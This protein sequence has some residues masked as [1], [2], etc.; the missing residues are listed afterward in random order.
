MSDTSASTS[1]L[2]SNSSF[3]Y[4]TSE[5]SINYGSVV[6]VYLEKY[7]EFP[8]IGK[9]ENSSEDT[10]TI[11][12]FD[13][14]FNDVWS[15]VKLKKGAEWRETL[16]KDKIILYDIQFTKGQRLK[17]DT[18]KALRDYSDEFLNKE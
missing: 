3:K 11:S 10:I 17:K 18:V 5:A 16:Q 13:G 14:A 8:Q 4:A 12:W 7:P 6:A 15:I 2:P 1:V 9:V